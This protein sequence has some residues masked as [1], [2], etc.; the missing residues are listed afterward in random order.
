MGAIGTSY[1]GLNSGYVQIFEWSEFSSSWRKRGVDIVG[2]EIG[3]QA[4]VS[5]SLSGDGAIVA[6]GADKNDGNGINSG[7]VRVYKWNGNIWSQRGSD[8]DGDSEGDYTGR[9]VS[10]SND[11]NVVIIGGLANYVRIYEWDDND[12]DWSKGGF[13][14]EAEAAGDRFGFSVDIESNGNVVAIGAYLND[15]NGKSSGH[16]RV[17]E[18]SQ[19]PGVWIQ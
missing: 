10:I 15:G 16:V 14:I 8:I 5:V 19:D 17:Y 13:G 2:E 3:D 1:Y 12:S 4:G 11:G 6:I 7:H 18:R 9:S